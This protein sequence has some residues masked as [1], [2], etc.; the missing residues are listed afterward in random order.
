MLRPRSSAGSQRPYCLFKDRMHLLT[1]HS[2]GYL[3]LKCLYLEME[4]STAKMRRAARVGYG[5]AD[6]ARHVIDTHQYAFFTFA[7]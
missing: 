3:L 5:L 1:E 6:V 2:T 4:G 7:S